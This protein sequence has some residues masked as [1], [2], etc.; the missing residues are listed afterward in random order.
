MR[1]AEIRLR[2][3][4]GHGEKFPRVVLVASDHARHRLPAAVRRTVAGLLRRVRRRVAVPMSQRRTLRLRSMFPET[5]RHPGERLRVPAG[6]RPGRH[7]DGQRTRVRNRLQGVAPRPGL[8]RA[9]EQR[10]Y[11]SMEPVRDGGGLG[12]RREQRRDVLVGPK[13]RLRAVRGT[14]G[15]V[16][17]PDHAPGTVPGAGLVGRLDVRLSRAGNA[18]LAAASFETTRSLV[19][20]NARKTHKLFPAGTSGKIAGS[21]TGRR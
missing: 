5:E 6:L 19:L 9:R 18:A 1:S 2:G 11:E 21:T 13:R 8:S 12:R 7:L 4:A 17:R 15:E 3:G 10:Q 20:Q 16:H 14:D